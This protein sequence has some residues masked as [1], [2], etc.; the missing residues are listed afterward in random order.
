MIVKSLVRTLFAGLILVSMVACSDINDANTP[1]WPGA[2]TGTN[3]STNNSGG[4]PADF[5]KVNGGTVSGQIA[6]SKVFIENRTVDIRDMYVCTHEVTQKEFKQYM[7]MYVWTIYTNGPYSLESQFYSGEGDNYPIFWTTWYAAIIYCN[8]RSKAE[9][10]TPCYYITINGKDETDIAKWMAL[11]LEYALPNTSE[12]YK[13]FDCEDGKYFYNGSQGS[14]AWQPL[15]DYTGESDTDGGIQFNTSANGYRLPTEVEWE[16]IARE[17]NKGIP[18]TQYLYS[19]SDDPVGFVVGDGSV[20]ENGAMI[21]TKA[22]NALGIY[23]MSGNAF[24]WVWD[25]YELDANISASTPATGPEVCY[26]TNDTSTGRVKKGGSHNNNIA[27]SK[28]YTRSSYAPG[29]ANNGA[30]FRL[31]R[32][33]D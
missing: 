10:L 24:E 11:D 13:C 18:A 23:D 30:G 26:S 32:N 28:I 27:I 9:G 22:P 7:K 21:K 8:L 4:I 20:S 33:A 29:F 2:G 31:V 14:G 19:G 5:V 17:G 6:D 3:T 12:P 1:M 16:Y 15:L 25:W